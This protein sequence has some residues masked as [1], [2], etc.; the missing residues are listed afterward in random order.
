MVP[1]FFFFNRLFSI[2]C[3]RPHSLFSDALFGSPIRGSSY[4]LFRLFILP[5]YYE[6]QEMAA[7]REDVLSAPLGP[8]KPVK[9][10]IIY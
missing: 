4:F 3:R 9:R 8:R 10:K 2:A 5:I 6:N 1:S 7:P